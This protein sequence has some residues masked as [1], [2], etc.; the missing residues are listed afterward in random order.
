MNTRAET[1]EVAFI[2]LLDRLVPK[3]ERIELL[4]RVFRESWAGRIHTAAMEASALSRE[5]NKAEARKQ[6][7]LDQMADGLLS[8]GEFLSMHKG[9]RELIADLRDPDNRYRGWRA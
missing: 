6:R 8:A 5:L 2:E 9:N 4:E 7:V 1:V 3:P